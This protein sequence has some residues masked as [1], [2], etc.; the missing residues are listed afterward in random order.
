MRLLIIA[1]A[2]LGL[3]ACGQPS[4]SEEQIA[5]NHP[6]PN[7]RADNTTTVPTPE[8]VPFTATI[9][10]PNQIKSNEEFVVE[11]TLKNLS[12]NNLTILHASGVFYFSIKDSN[13]KGVNTF[14]MGDVGIYRP[15]QGKGMIIEQYIYK[16]EKPG[17]YEVS[18]LAKFSVREGDNKKDLIVETDKASFEV[19]PLN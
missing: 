2:L 3:V 5:V 18:A 7:N 15:F 13:G 1:F 11:A 19:L 9:S 10:V 6:I 4:Q 14:A 17:Y 8:K 12:D 16:L